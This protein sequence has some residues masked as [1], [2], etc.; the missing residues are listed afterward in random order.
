MIGYL[1]ACGTSFFVAAK[2]LV[3]KK[4][5]SQ[6]DGT[7]S[8]FAS[9]AFAIPFY[10]ILLCVL[11]FLRLETFSYSE[12]FIYYAVLRSLTDVGAEWLKMLALGCG[13]VSLVSQFLALSPLFLAL[14]SPLI[15][16]DPITPQLVLALGIITLS[17]LIVAY[18][19]KGSRKRNAQE[20]RAI[21]YALGSAIFFSFNSALDR[22]AVQEASATLSAFTMTLFSGLVLL[23]ISL[24]MSKKKWGKSL[25]KNSSVFFLRGF[26]EVIFM[27]L[28]MLALQYLQAPIVVILQRF[29]V[30]LTVLGGKFLYN[31]HDFPKRLFAS[32]LVIIAGALVLW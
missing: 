21:L 13:E 15:T 31:E 12:K 29:S 5:S 30:V 27:T 17:S 25:R 18:K 14:T 32:L 11:F 6:V 22:L 4:L 2:D 26:L 20:N 16:S 10:L 1:A 3:S 8:A 23:P 19:P 24:A 9:F 7:L 28:K